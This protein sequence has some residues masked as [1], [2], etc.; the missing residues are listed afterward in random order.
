MRI[1]DILNEVTDSPY[2]FMLAKKTNRGNQYIFMNPAGTRFLVDISKEQISDGRYKAEIGF[3]DVS[4]KN[5]PII[6]PT[7]K[8]DAIKVFSTVGA[9]T[10]DFIKNSKDQVDE[11]IFKGKTKDPTRIKLYDMIARNINRFLP[12]F[13]FKGT[14]QDGEE[15]LYHFDRS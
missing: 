2:R 7:G 6:D 10:K 3:A 5:E 15:K 13:K 8:G 14:G 1:S 11:L 9:V 12:E 4:Q